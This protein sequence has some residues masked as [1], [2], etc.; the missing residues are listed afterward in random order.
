MGSQYLDTGWVNPAFTALPRLLYPVQY[1]AGDGRGQEGP[2]HLYSP[3]CWL[4]RHR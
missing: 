4:E 2:R 1:L 3:N